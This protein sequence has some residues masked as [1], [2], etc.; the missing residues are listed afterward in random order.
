MEYKSANQRVLLLI[1]S[2]VQNVKPLQHARLSWHVICPS[3]IQFP[4]QVFSSICGVAV[5]IAA[6]VLSFSSSSEVTGVLETVALT[7]P[8]RK[9][10]SGVI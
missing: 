3:S 1:E 8:D 5:S 6:T 9:I 7:Y 2:I 10:S 4:S